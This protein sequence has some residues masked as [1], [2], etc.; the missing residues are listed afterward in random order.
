M[1]TVSCSISLPARGSFHLSITVLVHYRLQAVFSLGKM[2][3]PDSDGVSR[4]PPY[5]GAA[6]VCLILVYRAITVFG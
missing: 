4:D 3:L 6:R 5:S 2:V 1:H